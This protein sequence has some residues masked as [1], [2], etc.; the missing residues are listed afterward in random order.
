MPILFVFNKLLWFFLTLLQL[1]NSD[2]GELPNLPLALPA[3]AQAP[4]EVAEAQAPAEAE[5]FWAWAETAEART[6]VCAISYPASRY[7]AMVPLP[8]Q[9]RFVPDRH[10]QSQ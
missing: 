8:K 9:L 4:A 3:E 2:A 10:Y 7:V 5:E 1:D 6:E